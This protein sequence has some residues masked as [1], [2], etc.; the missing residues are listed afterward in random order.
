MKRF[1]ALLAALPLL[2]EARAGEDFEKK[3]RPLLAEHCFKCHGAT[4][5]S[6]ELRL[7]SREA[8]IQGGKRGPAAI[9]G[10]PDASLLIQATAHK[11][12]LRMPPKEKLTGSQ[13]ASLRG[14]ITRGLPWPASPQA[15]NG[16]KT[17]QGRTPPLAGFSTFE[18]HGDSNRQQRPR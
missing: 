5:Q 11:G 9:A 18:T 13:L 14:W 16:K 8:I 17:C 15:Q 4:K 3:V 10:K 1:I 6:G 7:D 2:S 12:D